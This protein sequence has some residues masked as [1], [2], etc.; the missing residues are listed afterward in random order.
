MNNFFC[1]ISVFDET[2]RRA[3]IHHDFRQP[4][5]TKKREKEILQ[6]ISEELT[7]NQIAERLFIS[8]LN[9]DSQRKNLLA[10]S[11]V[12][13]AAFLIKLAVQNGLI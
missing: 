4:A 7:N 5:C 12:I 9:V 2:Y 10:K 6:L 11:N 3:F 1:C 13:I 8:P